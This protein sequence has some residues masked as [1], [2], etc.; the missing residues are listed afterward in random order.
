MLRKS[1][2]SYKFVVTVITYKF[3]LK[4]FY[5]LSKLNDTAGL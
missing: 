4:H 2:T 1:N 5:L 3:I